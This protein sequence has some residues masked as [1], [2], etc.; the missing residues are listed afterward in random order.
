MKAS[1]EQTGG[2]A[3]IRRSPER[4]QIGR[5]AEQKGKRSSLTYD[6]E[7]VELAVSFIFGGCL[8]TLLVPIFGAD[9]ASCF[10]SLQLLYR[11]VVSLERYP[12]T[13]FINSIP[14]REIVTCEQGSR[15]R[16]EDYGIPYPVLGQSFGRGPDWW[17]VITSRP[18]IRGEQRT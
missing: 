12:K 14:R 4:L 5:E 17:M 3:A 1:V 9:N 15:F 11:H 18:T 2:E 13:N 8:P 10:L 6:E 16:T 7:K